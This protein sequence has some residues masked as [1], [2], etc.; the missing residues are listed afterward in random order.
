MPS[1]IKSAAGA[2]GGLRAAA[3]REAMRLGREGRAP[4][5]AADE[6]RQQGSWIGR[7]PALFGA[8]AGAGV[9]MVVAASNTNE[10]FCT[11]NDE[12]C[13]AYGSWGIAFGAAL[14]A[15]IGTLAGYLVGKV[16]SR[17]HQRMKGHRE[18][19]EQ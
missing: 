2:P 18:T 12:D 15:G 7:H 1:T 11:G 4:Q 8:I 3:M 10:L 19:R 17:D 13:L 16:S 6:R 5:A 9:G 14:G